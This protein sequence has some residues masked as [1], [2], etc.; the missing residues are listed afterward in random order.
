M[1]LKTLF[2]LLLSGTLFSGVLAG[3]EDAKRASGNPLPKYRQVALDKA[4][5]SVYVEPSPSLDGEAYRGIAENI[6]RG[7]R[8]CVVMFWTDREQVPQSLPMSEDQVNAKSAHYNVN[9]NTGLDRLMLCS[10][11]QCHVEQSD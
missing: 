8:I 1:R 11:G 3:C 4:R 6:C 7:K 2:G 5:F 10:K 9:R